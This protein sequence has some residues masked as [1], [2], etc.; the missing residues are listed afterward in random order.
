MDKKLFSRVKDDLTGHYRSASSPNYLA[1]TP[2][3]DDQV[4]DMNWVIAVVK[5]RLL[6]MTIVAASIATLSGSFIIWNDKKI[7]PQYEG[8]F[9]VLVEPLTSDDRLSKLLV[10][11]QNNSL[12]ITDLTKLNHQRKTVPRWIIK[13]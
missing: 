6:V 2:E 7:V 11:A 3:E 13:V 1:S 8:K 5:R 10:Q 9:T 4:L 12:G